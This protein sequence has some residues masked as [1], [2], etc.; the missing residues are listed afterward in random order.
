MRRISPGHS[1]YAGT[2]HG[3]LPQS[4]RHE[5]LARLPDDL[6]RVVETFEAHYP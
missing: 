2:F 3:D 4:L 6:R 5:V 1:A